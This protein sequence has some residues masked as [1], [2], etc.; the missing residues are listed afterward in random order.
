LLRKALVVA[1]KL[2]IAEFREWVQRELNGYKQGDTLPE[3]RQIKG[4]AEAFNP[5]Q[6]RWMPVIWENEPRRLT[7]CQNGQP[8]AEIEDLLRHDDGKDRFVMP[9][10]ESVQRT[11]SRNSNLGLIPNLILS[12][13]SLTG[14][15]DAVRNIILEWSLKLELDGILGENMTF[16]REEKQKAAGHTYNIKNF[17]GVLG[18]VQGETVQVGDFNSIAAEL[19]QKGVPQGE[20]NELENIF[21][22]LRAASPEQRKGLIQRGTQWLLRNADKIGKLSDTIRSWFENAP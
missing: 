18:N 3:Y 1:T 11:L 4:N 22:D 8:V 12:R 10:P 16:S 9:Y 7:R 13:A 2:Q 14:I 15:L 19:K 6:N 20:R 21:D 17:K 5:F